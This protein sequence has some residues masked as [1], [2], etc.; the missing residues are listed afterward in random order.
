MVQAFEQR[1]VRG[2][3]EVLRKAFAVRLK[4]LDGIRRG[5][6]VPE[7]MGIQVFNRVKP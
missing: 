5:L 7:H 1:Q 2:S 4:N 6:L 3:E